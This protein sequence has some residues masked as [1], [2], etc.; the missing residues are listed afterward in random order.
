L[1]Q[2]IKKSIGIIG[3]GRLGTTL[4]A[5][6]NKRNISGIELAAISSKTRD[7]LIRAKDIIGTVKDNMLFT[8]DNNKCTAKADCVFICTPDD[9]IEKACKSI[10]GANPKTLKGKLF[11]HFSGAKTLEVLSSASEA[12]AHTASIHP[13]KSFAS[14]ND[15]IDTLPQTIYGVTYP[16]KPHNESRKFIDY[17]VLSMGGTIIEVEDEKKSLYHAAA[18]VASNYLVA[19][20]NY[21]VSIHEGIGI[22]KEDSLRALSGL[23]DGTVANIK[24]LGPGQALTGPIARGDIGTVEEHL[25]SFSKHLGPGKD[26]VYSIMGYEAAKLACENGWIKK[27]VLE[28][29]RKIF[30]IQKKQ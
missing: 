4:A 23:I 26:L 2:S 5:A 30:K 29:F 3:A 7:A 22:K 12:G 21:A 16:I 18:C 11:I 28:E 14:I 20:I 27:P 19:L 24:K 17:F 25:A 15:S 8:T 9:I 10:A 6:I 1:K 13:I